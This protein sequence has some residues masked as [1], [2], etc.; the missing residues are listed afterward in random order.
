MAT[1]SSSTLPINN[2]SLS[3]YYLAFDIDIDIEC[4]Q[5]YSST[6]NHLPKRDNPNQSL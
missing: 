3:T 2:A 6:S 4:I 1:T 5:A